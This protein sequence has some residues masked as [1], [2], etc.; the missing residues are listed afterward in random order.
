MQQAQRKQA[1]KP[2]SMNL[3]LTTQ[4]ETLRAALGPYYVSYYPILADVTGSPKAAFML[5]HALYCTKMAMRDVKRQDG[6]F[7]KTTESWYQ[8]TGL[9]VREIETARK[10]LRNLGVLKEVRRGMPA[11]LWYTLDLNKLAELICNHVN[12]KYR[13]WSWEDRYVKALLGK[14]IA[15]YAPFAWMSGSAISGLYLSYLFTASRN[16]LS[17]TSLTIRRDGQTWLNSPMKQTL[18]SLRL[19]RKSLM[20]ARAKLIDVGI[21]AEMRDARVHSHLIS[22][23]LFE[24]LPSKITLEVN[25]HHSLSEYDKQVSRNTTNNMYPKRVTRDTESAKQEIPK[26][27]NNIFSLRRTSYAVSA[28]PIYKEALNTAEQLLHNP[29]QV[30][31]TES[32]KPLVIVEKVEP[33]L[34]PLLLDMNDLI[35]PPKIALKQEKQ[36]MLALLEQKQVNELDQAQLLLDEL[37]GNMQHR[38]IHNPIA[39]L[40][41]LIENQ[42]KGQFIV[43]YAHKVQHARKQSLIAMQQRVNNQ[44]AATVSPIDLI[45]KEKGQAMM[46]K[47]RAKRNSK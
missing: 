14:S 19:G 43:N 17:N 25:K 15:V 23:I 27:Q 46:D 40:R 35:F 33:V 5:G 30:H 3:E 24:Q 36:S 41:T 29:E 10:V 37:T 18:E 12:I 6:S 7:W 31:E 13:D 39:Y 21:I 45:A 16:A 22:R 9:S 28:L 32:V 38:T 2:Q 1:Y 34:K 20:N 47:L 8:E 4:V 11:K 26:P 44:S 42:Q